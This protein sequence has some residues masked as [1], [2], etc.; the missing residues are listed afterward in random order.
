MR[1]V[2]NVI[3]FSLGSG[4]YLTVLGTQYTGQ[5]APFAQDEDP[6]YPCNPNMGRAGTSGPIG[7]IVDVGAVL[8][9]SSDVESSVSTGFAIGLGAVTTEIRLARIMDFF[10]IC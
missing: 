6:L 3:A 1:S 10:F 5:F 9:W 7:I 4:D 2:V 8:T